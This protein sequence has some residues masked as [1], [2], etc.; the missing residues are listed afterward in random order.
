MSVEDIDESAAFYR[1]VVVALP[2][3]FTGARQHPVTRFMSE[4]K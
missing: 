4:L 3:M 1:D 2:Y